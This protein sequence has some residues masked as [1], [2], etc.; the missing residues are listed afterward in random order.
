MIY[1]VTTAVHLDSLW[2][3]MLVLIPNNRVLLALL[4]QSMLLGTSA[5]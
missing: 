4:F 2:L 3:W 1:V 5:V